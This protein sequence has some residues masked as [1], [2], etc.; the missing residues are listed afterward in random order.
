MI[1]LYNSVLKKVGYLGLRT[2][3]FRVW[4]FWSP[5]VGDSLKAC[6]EGF[7]KDS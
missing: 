1:S 5:R 3:G 2:V 7:R 6:L 4:G